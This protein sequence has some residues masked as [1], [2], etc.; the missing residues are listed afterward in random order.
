MDNEE[1]RR[2]SLAARECEHTVY[3]KTFRLLLPTPTDVQIEML[4]AGDD[5]AAPLVMQ[6][7]VLE[8]AVIGWSGVMVKDL[9]SGD[10]VENETAEFASMLVPLLFAN[11]PD[12]Y[13]ELAA[14]LVGRASE[15]NAK[16]EAA[17]KN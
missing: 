2:R 5:R 3:G 11:R 6:R 8:R 16:L 15:R 13:E 4:R 9:V 7:A 1:I 10:D 17:R 14:F 12:I